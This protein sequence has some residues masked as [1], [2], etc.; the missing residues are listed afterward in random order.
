MVSS[1]VLIPTQELYIFKHFDLFFCSRCVAENL[2]D[3]A[4]VKHTTVYD[5]LDGQCDS[6]AI[7]LQYFRWFISCIMVGV[8]A[9]I[10]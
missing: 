4:F 10:K 2:G 8:R 9:I 3:V 5:N 7:K 6:E 1:S